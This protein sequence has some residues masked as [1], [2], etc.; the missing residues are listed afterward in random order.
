MVFKPQFSRW[1]SNACSQGGT[2]KISMRY[3]IQIEIL[4]NLHPEL[5]L[6][7]HRFSTIKTAL[8]FCWPFPPP[9][10]QKANHVLY[11]VMV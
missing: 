11:I 6:H 1:L 8:E 3:V 5:D 2:R 10:D 9:C 7:S 4:H